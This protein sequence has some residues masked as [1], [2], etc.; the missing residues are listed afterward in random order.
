M[1]LAGCTVGDNEKIGEKAQVTIDSSVTYQVMD[2]FG[3]SSRVWDDLHLSNT[4][5][6]VIPRTAQQKILSLLY[7]DLGL[8]RVRPI[9]DAGI[10]LANDNSNPF[11]F[12]S[13][14]FNFEWERNDA[15]VE[16]VKQAI[17]YG[18]QV[19][20]PTPIFLEKWMTESNP[21]EYVE[22][23]LAILL[24][25]REAGM[26]VPFYSIVNEPSYRRGGIWSATWLT[27]VVKSLGRRIRAEALRTMLVIP[28]DLNPTEAYKRAAPVLEDPEARKYVGAL[29]YHLYGA[30]ARD[31]RRMRDLSLRYGIPLWMSEYSERRYI[32]YSGGMRWARRIHDLIDRRLRRAGL[33]KPRQHTRATLTMGV[34]RIQC[35]ITKDATRTELSSGTMYGR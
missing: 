21:E 35:P 22:W 27:R 32:S 16:F 10:E 26:E 9:L 23:A 30:R 19:Y 13:T 18:L 20:F 34:G 6:T 25:W 12:D 3:S 31:L 15:H 14:K 7:K 8:T 33:E 17:L 4:R 2:G 28:D 24:R 1:L 5:R 11:T 29:A